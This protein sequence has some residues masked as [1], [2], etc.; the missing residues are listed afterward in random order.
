MGNVSY[1][2][3]IDMTCLYVFTYLGQ[4]CPREMYVIM[5]MFY[6]LSNRVAPCGG[7]SLE[8]GLV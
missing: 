3:N 8:T 6:V 5:K 4:H 2:I 1:T 7:G